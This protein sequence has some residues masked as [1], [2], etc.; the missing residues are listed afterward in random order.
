MNNATM[1]KMRELRLHGMLRAFRETHESPTH[2]NLTP[3][4]F[5]AHLV[6]AEWDERH[7]RTLQRLIRNASFRHRCRI[8]DVVITAGRNIDKNMLHRL[9]ACDW[10][11][12][13]ENLIITGATGVGKSFIAC[14]IGHEACVRKQ[15]VGYVNC[16]KL[17]SHLKIAKADGTYARELKTLAR[18][19]LLI[20]DDFGLKQLDAES[21]LMM[22][23]FIEDR[24][25]TKS[26]IISSQVPVSKWFEIIG[27]PTIAD[28]ICDRLVHNAQTINL[29]G[30]S[31]RKSRVK[32]SGQD[33]PP[34][35]HTVEA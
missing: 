29:T 6:D 4:E 8:E 2:E 25:G 12:K 35:M 3:D 32:I 22:L 26:T 23:E 27:D 24:H 13:A 16:M 34:V 10:I 33:L 1:D 20:L 17:F 15:R 5:L 7:N 9:A 18:K 11:G 14:A 31:M 21:R 28:A 19:D 30:G